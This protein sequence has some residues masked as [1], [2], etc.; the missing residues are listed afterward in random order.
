MKDKILVFIIGVLVGA[1]VTASGFLVYERINQDT[2]QVKNGERMQMME[3]PDGEEPP[4]KP[5]GEQ[6]DENRPAPPSRNGVF[7]NNKKN[8]GG[9]ENE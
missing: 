2:N 6:N 5:E 1:I 3:R 8:E 7:T 4:A 9:K